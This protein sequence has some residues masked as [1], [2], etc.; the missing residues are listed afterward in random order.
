MHNDRDRVWA[1]AARARQKNLLL[2]PKA[3]K[4]ACLSRLVNHSTQICVPLCL[5]I[6]INNA[7]NEWK[8][9]N[10]EK[11]IVRTYLKLIDTTHFNNGQIIC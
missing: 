11:H 9:M 7:D 10:A 2:K 6:G 5:H 1:C 4:M 3:F 8:L